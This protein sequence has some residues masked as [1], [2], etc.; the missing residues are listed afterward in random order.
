MGAGSSGSRQI[1]GKVKE[2]FPDAML[3]NTFSPD[4]GSIHAAQFP[5]YISSVDISALLSLLVM[6]AS[7]PAGMVVVPCLGL[8]RSWCMAWALV[9]SGSLHSLEHCDLSGDG[10][11]RPPSPSAVVSMLPEF[12]SSTRGD[13][14]SVTL[15]VCIR[16]SQCDVL[17][18]VL[19]EKKLC[20]TSSSRNFAECL[21]LF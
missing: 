7:W 13:I 8:A 6:T 20:V 1:D 15:D 2:E 11:V 14:L 9:A 16:I 18:C 10:C 3:I 19:L 21:L 5:G 12:P 17:F 4:V